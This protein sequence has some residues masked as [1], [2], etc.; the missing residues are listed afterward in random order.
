[1]YHDTSSVCANGKFFRLVDVRSL[2][3]KLTFQRIHL[4]L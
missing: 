1:M 4:V 2:E 3:V